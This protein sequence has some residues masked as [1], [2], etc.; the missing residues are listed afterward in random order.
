VRRDHKDA[1][2]PDLPRR[3]ARDEPPHH[4]Q[5]IAAVFLGANEAETARIKLGKRVD[6]S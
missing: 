1:F 6:K 4:E 3:P 5:G 2:A